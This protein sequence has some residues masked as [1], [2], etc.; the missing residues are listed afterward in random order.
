VFTYYFHGPA[1]VYPAPYRP[2]PEEVAG[3]LEP[4]RPSHRRLFAL[5]WGVE[6]ADPARAV[7][8]WLTTHAYPARDRWY[9]AVRV[10]VYGLAPL[11]AEPAVA[12]DA[13]FGEAIRLRGYALGEGPFAP[14]DVVPVTLFWEAEAEVPERYKVFLHL[15]DE[16]GNLVAQ[17]DSEPQGNL[18]PTDTWTPA[19]VLADRHGVL[20][21]PDLAAGDYTLIVGLYHL[22]GGERLPVTLGS[23]PVDDHVALGTVAVGPEEG[24]R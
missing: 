20:L 22:V 14:G 11:P 4:L 15:L 21:P 1:P 9:G 13:R 7:E 6:E 2:T 19:Q 23:G 18:V 17:T 16:G 12:L 5:Y 3:W 24:G 8:G 10:A